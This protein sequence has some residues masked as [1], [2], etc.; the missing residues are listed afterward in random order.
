MTNSERRLPRELTNLR[1]NYD[2]GPI[3]EKNICELL[4]IKGKN[5]SDLEPNFP[6]VIDITLPQTY[7]NI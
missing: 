3:F 1:W 4:Q 6:K 5:L 7:L 2:L